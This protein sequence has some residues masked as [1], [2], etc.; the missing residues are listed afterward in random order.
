M[1]YKTPSGRISN[2]F[3]DMTHQ[4]HLLIAG[5]TGS[6]KSV[7]INGIIS[8]IL[9]RLPGPSAGAAQLILIDPKRVEL[10]A[11]ADLPHTI[12]HADGFNP[13][14]WQKALAL[15]VDIMDS[16]YEQMKRERVKEFR[17]GD[18]YVIIDEWAAI[19][20]NGGAPCYRAALR[21]LSEGRAAKVH[22]IMATQVPKATIIPTEIRENFTARLCLMTENSTQSRIIMEAKG[23]E[24]LPDPK[25]S[26]Y[27]LGYYKLSGKNCKLYKVPYI[28]QEELDRIVNHWEAQT[29]VLL[30]KSGLLNKIAA[31]FDFGK[32]YGV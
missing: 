2:L 18:L 22:V 7:A 20:K 16:R 12:C 31:W 25:R 27:A 26:G 8:T 23:C 9:Y 4:S 17:G 5:A 30:R 3:L 15:A 32:T 13:E 10:A 19:S 1:Y 28:P 11:Y 24:E 29:P 21:L 6:G 14:K